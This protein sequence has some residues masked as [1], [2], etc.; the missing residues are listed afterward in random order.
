MFDIHVDTW[1]TYTCNYSCLHTH[2]TVHFCTDTMEN[3]AKFRQFVVSCCPEVQ[4]Y[5]DNVDIRRKKHT[6]ADVTLERITNRGRY[7]R[8][9]LRTS[10]DESRMNNIKQKYIRDMKVRKLLYRALSH[11]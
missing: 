7:Y 4:V 3:K 8:R 10:T 5:V 2:S 6:F 9:I 11:V 1:L